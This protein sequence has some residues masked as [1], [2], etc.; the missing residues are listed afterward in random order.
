MAWRGVV[1]DDAIDAQSRS[2][3]RRSRAPSA[4]PPEK[5]HH[6]INTILHLFADRRE[7]L[8]WFEL[9]GNDTAI[10]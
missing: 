8:S 4:C 6:R 5:D 7:D 3:V 10:I 1:M 9:I 2:A